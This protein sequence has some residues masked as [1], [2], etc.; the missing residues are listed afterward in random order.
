[1]S[2]NGD[3]PPPRIKLWPKTNVYSNFIFLRQITYLWNG[4][5]AEISKIIFSNR[6]LQNYKVFNFESFFSF[7]RII[8]KRTPAAKE[9]QPGSGGTALRWLCNE[10]T[11]FLKFTHL[12]TDTQF[13]IWFPGCIKAMMTKNV[14]GNRRTFYI[15][16]WLNSRICAWKFFMPSTNLGFRKNWTIPTLL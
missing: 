7:S 1:M 14:F 11:I 5:H 9:R 10:M 13:L 15:V 2:K 16:S 6:W 12:E 4:Q 3:F 8:R